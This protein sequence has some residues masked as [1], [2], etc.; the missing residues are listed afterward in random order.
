DPA[1]RTFVADAV[2]NHNIP[3]AD[4]QALVNDV[5]SRRGISQSQA[6]TIVAGW[7]TDLRNAKSTG[8]NIA[9]EAASGTSRIGIWLFVAIIIGLAVSCWGGAVGAP[10]DSSLIPIARRR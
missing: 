8:T 9:N 6:E 7:Q 3:P 5:S 1:F 2:Q 4:K 10:D